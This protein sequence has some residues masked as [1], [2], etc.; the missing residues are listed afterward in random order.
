MAAT[1]LLTLL[2]ALQAG[3]SAGE[4]PQEKYVIST[5]WARADTCNLAVAEKVDVRTVASDPQKWVG[6][7]VAVGGYWRY[8][9]LFAAATDGLAQDAQAGKE[10]SG[11]RVGIYGTEKLL[12]AAPNKPL[13]YIAVGIVGLCENLRQGT[14]MVFGYCHYTDGP[15][16]AV[17]EM[18]PR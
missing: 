11:R 14:A 18:R 16:L 17:A 4:L 1:I 15:F 5:I 13:A 6:K 2:G 12:S 8:R 10:S 9:A 7:C 3:S